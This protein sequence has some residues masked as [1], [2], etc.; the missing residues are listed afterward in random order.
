MSKIWITSD[1]HFSH[2]KEFVWKA[3]GYKDVDEMNAKQVEKFNSVVAPEDT[4]Y[5]CGDCMLNDNEKGIELLKQLN[6]KKHIILGNH[7]SNARKKLYE[8]IV[9][10]VSY[11]EMIKYKKIMFYLSHYPTITANPGEEKP[12]YNLHGH[13]HQKTIFGPYP[14][15]IHIGVDSWDGYPVSMDRVIEL[16]K[17]YR[18]MNKAVIPNTFTEEKKSVFAKF[19]K[20]RK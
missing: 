14:N 3:R 1:L 12:I 4:V 19:F 16:V 17:E 9:E 7:D 18:N 13:T 8:G 5:I 15:C 10:S 11:A 6:G 2:D 20:R